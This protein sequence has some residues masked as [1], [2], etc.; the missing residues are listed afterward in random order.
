[1]AIYRLHHGDDTI[2][3]D[4]VQVFAINGDMADVVNV[5]S[6]E[7]WVEKLAVEGESV[8]LGGRSLR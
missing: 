1:V 2:G 7:S 3:E 6:G 5:R 4:D 8:S